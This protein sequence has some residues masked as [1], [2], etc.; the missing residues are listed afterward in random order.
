M[1]HRFE[2]EAQFYPTL[3]RLPFHLRMKLDATGVKLS[4]EI[5]H[6]FSLEERWALCHL[7]V[8]GRDEREVF[9]SYL[10]FLV[11]RYSNRALE[12]TEIIDSQLWE[13]SDSVPLPVE[14]KSSNGPGGRIT[15][16][17][18]GQWKNHERYVL[19]KTALSKNDPALFYAA[20]R[21]LRDR[22]RQDQS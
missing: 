18:W 13:R 4:L 3:E 22:I 7:P 2:F 14:E 21:E 5:W 9:V 11:K 16:A 12:K 1:F 17:E 15:L 20:S 19:Y 8:D 6:A 10:A